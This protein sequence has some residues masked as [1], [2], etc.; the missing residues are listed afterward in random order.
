MTG[1]T[2]SALSPLS[3]ARAGSFTGIT[4]E[5]AGAASVTL[6]I[7]NGEN[8]GTVS[9]ATGIQKGQRV[10]DNSDIPADTFV[11]S[12]SG[13]NI[14]LSRAVTADNPAGVK[15]PPLGAGT[16]S[17]FTF[18]ATQPIG[19]ELI[20]ATSV[21]Q[22]SHWGSSIIMDGEYDEDRAYIYS[23]GT[24][25]GRSVSSGATKSYSWTKTSTYC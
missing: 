18:N 19:V 12:I 14:T 25:T 13:T 11:H 5:Q 10:I 16:A 8:T 24:K 7:A 15:F 1:A 9:S 2:G 17:T 23:V 6:S 4:R 22:I 3:R 20:Q 21:P